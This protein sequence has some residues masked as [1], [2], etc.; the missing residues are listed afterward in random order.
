MLNMY[1]GVVY[2]CLWMTIFFQL[3]D[4]GVDAVSQGADDVS[5]LHHAEMSESEKLT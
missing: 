3:L 2:E 1:A 4:I 5:V